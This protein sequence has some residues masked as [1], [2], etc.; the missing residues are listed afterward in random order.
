MVSWLLFRVSANATSDYNY[1]VDN[2]GSCQLVEGLQP[3]D[4][5]LQCK[6]NPDQVSYWKPTGY[7]RIPLT[8]CQGGLEFDYTS[9]EVVCPGHEEQYEESHRG[10]SGFAFFIVVIVLPVAVASAIGYYIYRQWDGKIGSIRL[11]ESGS[12]F[13]AGQ[14]WIRYPVAVVAAV[15][16]VV[17][18]IPLLVASLWRSA[19]GMFGGGRTYTTRQ[20]FARGRSDYA[21]V[22]P[23]EDELL[24]EDE[25]EDV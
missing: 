8:T 9:Q 24:G 12:A 16:A 5:S 23:D 17:A 15:I 13:D 2:D 21:I 14:P 20:S 11:G 19:T 18:A 3:Q 7:R 22:D 4:H 1:A 10:L 25:D 6:E